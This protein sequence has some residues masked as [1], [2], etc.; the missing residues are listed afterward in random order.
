[1]TMTMSY[2]ELI[3]IPT[4]EERIKYLDLHGRVA[5]ETFGS[6]RYTNQNFYHSD[7]WKTIRDKII[8]RDNACDLGV[9]GYEIYRR[10]QVHHI[11]PITPED[12]FDWNE[13]KLLNPEN[14]I[15]VHFRT[16]NIIHYGIERQESKL[17]KERKPGDMCPWR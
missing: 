11:N 1:M 5:S 14:L 9:P 4:F 7:E 13:D 8:L 15:C 10:L 16:H 3:Q 6:K 12:I 17:P 2:S